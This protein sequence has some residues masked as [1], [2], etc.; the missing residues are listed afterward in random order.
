MIKKLENCERKGKKYTITAPSILKIGLPIAC[1]LGVIDILFI[2]SQRY[3]WKY[4]E[5]SDYIG[6]MI[7]S[8]VFL[9]GV[10]VNGILACY[11]YIWKI[12]FDESNILYRSAYGNVKE[13]KIQDI[14]RYTEKRKKQYKF[15]SG[16]KKLFQYEIDASGAV[17][18]LLRILENKNLYAE[19]LIPSRKEH[20]I[21][22]P[23]LIHKILP[24]AGLIISIIFTTILM[25]SGD[26]KLWMYLV[27]GF[28]IIA[29]LYYTGDY[30]YDKTE[31]KDN[32]V[33]QEFLRKSRIVEFSQI[34]GIQEYKSKNEKEY[35]VIKIKE[36]KPLK[37]RKYNE[38]VDVLLAR[39]KEEKRNNAN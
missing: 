1:F 6:Q 33:R 37:I 13:I 17:Y 32:I 20:C 7:F 21:V 24:L 11:G 4:V 9:V 26:G 34:T 12:E 15:Y 5:Q 19:E 27:L 35:I 10:L 29:L 22:E 36:Q 23:M 8:S 38:N 2:L 30:M 16:K 14:S 31:I 28:C 18:D 25:I 3:N 39:L